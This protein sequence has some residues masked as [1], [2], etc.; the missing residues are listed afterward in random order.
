MVTYSSGLV[1]KEVEYTVQEEGLAEAQ[2]SAHRKHG[3]RC[4]NLTQHCCGFRVQDEL[5]LAIGISFD[6]YQLNR[7]LEIHLSL[8][9]HG[10]LILTV[11]FVNLLLQFI[12]R[13]VVSFAEINATLLVDLNAIASTLIPWWCQLAFVM[14]RL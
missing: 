10:T 7:W 5:V 6:A 8:V 3:D 11:A 13:F 1:V 12:N 4:I 9:L 14:R 2:P